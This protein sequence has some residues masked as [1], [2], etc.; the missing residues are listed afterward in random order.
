MEI[1]NVFTASLTTIG[2]AALLIGLVITYK[3]HKHGK[4]PSR[5][6]V[7]L[8][9]IAGIGLSGGLLKSAIDTVNRY[10]A[11]LS[12]TLTSQAL[13]VSIPLI[14]GLAAAV[15]IY[16]DWHTKRIEKATPW[17]ALVLPAMLPLSAVL[18]SALGG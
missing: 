2:A 11:N 10:A 16:Y 17:I 4:P 15:W 5:F 9:L 6:L 18:G 8:M 3:Q 12:G 1:L 7:A 14:A 13:G